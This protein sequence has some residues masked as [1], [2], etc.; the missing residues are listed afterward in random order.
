MIEDGEN[1][2]DGLAKTSENA[3]DLTGIS[4]DANVA[5][6][7]TTTT[8]MP[9]ALPNPL[10]HLSPVNISCSHMGGAS[11]SVPEDVCVLSPVDARLMKRIQSSVLKRML[12]TPPLQKMTPVQ[13][14]PVASASS[15][16]DEEIETTESTT[17]SMKVVDSFDFNNISFELKP[18]RYS[19]EEVSSSVQ[20]CQQWQVCHH[21][22]GGRKKGKGKGKDENCVAQ[23]LKKIH[24]NLRMAEDCVKYMH[25]FS[26]G[27]VPCSPEAAIVPWAWKTEFLKYCD[28]LIRW[29]KDRAKEIK[30]E[31]IGPIYNIFVEDPLPSL[32][33]KLV[34]P[35]NSW[36][37]C[38]HGQM[39]AS[40]KKILWVPKEVYNALS[41]HFC[42]DLE[43]LISPPLHPSMTSP[44]DVSDTR[45]QF[46]LIISFRSQ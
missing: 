35:I 2:E 15:A 20:K 44:S 21:P 10:P 33:K 38:P 7:T 43:E 30:N 8:T 19:K 12:G 31:K 14:V 4:A 46:L 42:Q 26:N 16:E 40:N 22:H 37:A 41:V 5:S 34:G 29:R 24:Q 17:E 9:F 25:H 1:A 6:A 45:G 11:V 18:H 28:K 23:H 36:I 32:G 27:G 39:Q 3:V 13:A